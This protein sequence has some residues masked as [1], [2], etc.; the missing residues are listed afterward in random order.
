MLK[1]FG[2]NRAIGLALTK[3]FWSVI[4]APITLMLIALSLTKVEQGYYFTFTSLLALQVFF[5]LGLVTV[6]AQ[7]ISHEFISLSWGS[8]G[9]IIGDKTKKNRVLKV[10]RP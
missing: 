3:R 10:A 1:Y 2:I 8:R 4:A 5:E 9:E 7:F 6:I